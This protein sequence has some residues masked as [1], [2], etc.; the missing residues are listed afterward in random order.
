M[1][2]NKLFISHQELDKQFLKNLELRH[3]RLLKFS[4]IS[5]EKQTADGKVTNKGEQK[6]ALWRK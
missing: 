1:D 3:Y 5:L 6:G 2:I 4:L